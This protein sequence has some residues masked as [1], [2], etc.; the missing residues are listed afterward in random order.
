MDQL[1]GEH[2]DALGGEAEAVAEEVPHALDV[3]D[4]APEV[5]VAA[6]RA[7]VGDADEHGALLAAGVEER[8]REGPHHR[9]RDPVGAADARDA[10]ALGALDGA[11]AG[12]HGERRPAV[13]APDRRHPMGP[14]AE[15]HGW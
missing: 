10:V 11:L 3:V 7:G 6:P 4:G 15:V 5:A 1:T 13:L 8:G 12:D 2:D 9:Q 14:S